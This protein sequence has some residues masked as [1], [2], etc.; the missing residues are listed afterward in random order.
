MLKAPS[1]PLPD[2]LI[3]FDLLPSCAGVDVQVVAALLA[4]SV[5]RIWNDV[6]LGDL[7]QPVKF[8]PRSTR[9]IVGDLRDYIA[10]ARANPHPKW[11]GCPKSDDA[12]V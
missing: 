10:N 11:K 9:W 5:P 6:K 1:R 12:E 7:P 2:A 8:G 4:R 3:H